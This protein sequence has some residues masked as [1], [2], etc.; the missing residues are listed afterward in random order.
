MSQSIAG[1]RRSV[2]FGAW[3]QCPPRPA[4]IRH[5]QRKHSFEWRVRQTLARQRQRPEHQ[6]PPTA[7]LD[8][9]SR[10]IQLIRTKELAFD[11]RENDD[12]ILKQGGPV[13]L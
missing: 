1:Q 7:V 5:V 11:V 13:D 4:P 9:C 8:K 12:V 2:R 10:E 6:K 3:N